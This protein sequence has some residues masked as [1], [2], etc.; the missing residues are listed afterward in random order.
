M[1]VKIFKVFTQMNQLME[2]N[3][4]DILVYKDFV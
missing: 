1:I 3:G 4:L 2:I